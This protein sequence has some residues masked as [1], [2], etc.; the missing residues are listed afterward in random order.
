MNL[1]SPVWLIVK[2]ALPYNN[3]QNNLVYWSPCSGMKLTANCGH[4][5]HGVFGAERP[6]AEAVEDRKKIEVN[7]LGWLWFCYSKRARKSL[8]LNYDLIFE[9]GL[10]CLLD[11][12]PA[13]F[14]SSFQRSRRDS[15]INERQTASHRFQTGQ[16]R[17]RHVRSE[18]VLQLF[19]MVWCRS[20]DKIWSSIALATK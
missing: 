15:R 7:F 18:S 13:V 2:S 8:E 10:C 19:V 12:T 9:T 6:P 11:D 1:C 20:E 3:V 5:C 17:C 4:V 16:Q 14:A